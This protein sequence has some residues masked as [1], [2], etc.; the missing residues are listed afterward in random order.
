VN[1]LYT[2]II[3][4]ITQ[5]IEFVFVFAEQCFDNYGISVLAVSLAVSFLCLPIYDVAEKWQQIERDI[6]KKLKPK[7]AKIKAVFSGDE[8]YMMLSVLYRQNHYHPVYAL[9]GSFGLLL[10]IPFFIAAYTFLSHQE[11]LKG[12]PFLF[13]ADLGSPDALL[14]LTPALRIN[15]FPVLMTLINCAS[16]AVYTKGAPLRDKLQLYVIAA[17][18]L[19]LLYDS[20]AALTLYWTCNNIFSFIKNIL[21]KYTPSSSQHG[22]SLFIPAAV[23]IAGFDVFLWFFQDGPFGKRFF[24][25]AV[26]VVL[27]ALALCAKKILAGFSPIARTLF[28][29][30]KTVPLFFV[31]AFSLVLLTGFTIPVLIIGSSPQEF[32]FI[33]NVASPWHFIFHALFLSF[34]VFFFWGAVIYFLFKK[35]APP[36]LSFL[37]TLLLL[38]SLGNV[39]IFSGD[40]GSISNG[41][42]FETPS[43][44][45]PSW[46]EG[47]LNIALFFFLAWVLLFLIR[48]KRVSGIFVFSCMVPAVLLAVSLPETARIQREY[49]NLRQIK[50]AD[51]GDTA[52][53]STPIIEKKFSFSRDKKNVLVIMADRAF[54]PFVIPI[55]DEATE[56]YR[57][58]DGFVLYPNTVSFG[59]HTVIGTPPIWGGYEYTPAE[60]NKRVG[61]PLVKKVNEALLTLP[62]ILGESGF[63]V[64]VTDPSWANHSW[65][66]DVRIFENVKNVTAMNLIGHY[67]NLWYKSRGFKSGNAARQIEERVFWFSLLKIS[68]MAA[69][70]LIYDIGDY[71]KIPNK[72]DYGTLVDSYAVLDFLPELTAYDSDAPGVLLMTNEVPH[73]DTFTQYPDYVPAEHVT[74]KGNGVFADYT[75][76]HTNAAFYHVFGK[77]LDE[78]KKN[79]VYDNTRIIIVADHGTGMTMPDSDV[80]FTVQGNSFYRYNPVLMVKDF[81]AHGTLQTD[82]RFM[83]NA[84]VPLLALK[85]IVDDPVNPQ[86]GKPLSDES[87]MD[88]AFIT[89]N[90]FF[91]AHEH[92]RNNF[93]IKD[94]EWVHVHDNV[95]N[96]DNWSETTWDEVK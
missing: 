45:R 78:L 26:T 33:E 4:P 55:F 22:K 17:L 50:A 21:Y 75:S 6:Q 11:V 51:G 90:N 88:G 27:F 79:G 69:R 93:N 89:T 76:Y 66:P 52:L 28:A 64:T 29:S 73:N 9:R 39:F 36:V 94:D 44:L 70:S 77:Y 20:P 62:R 85:G 35:T 32:S 1:V 72:I 42:L 19:V 8:Q 58:Y 24:L 81:D 80:N 23:A 31:N 86:T 71:W 67:N 18:F 61:E 82:V 54:N 30:R 14:A 92:K 49:G 56:L 38:F 87:K 57:Q 47:A 16:A 41:F 46:G 7:A 40:Y 34:G 74:D 3:S 60:I 43:R 12:L 5:I 59:A 65:I 63:Q 91:M 25:I 48:Q 84:D 53:A 96:K 10:Q 68:P 83:T 37:W 95:F 2:I 15:I 13:V